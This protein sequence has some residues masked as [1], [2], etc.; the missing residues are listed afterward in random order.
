MSDRT[1]GE[2]LRR[3]RAAAGLSTRELAGKIGCDH[4]LVVRWEGDEADTAAVNFSAAS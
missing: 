1:L 2:R 3:L 4:S